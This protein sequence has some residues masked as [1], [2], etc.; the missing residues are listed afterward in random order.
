MISFSRLSVLALLIAPVLFVTA[1]ARQEGD[2]FTDKVRQAAEEAAYTGPAL[3]RVSDDD[4]NVYLFGTVHTMRPETKWQTEAVIAALEEADALY[5]EADVSSTQAQNDAAAVITEL[6]LLTNG[7]TLRDI[8]PEDAE[9]EVEEA[10]QLLGIPLQGLDN[11]Q[12]WYAS[13]ALT[14]IHLEKLGFDRSAGVEGVLGQRAARL[15]IPSRYLET[16]AEQLTIVASIPTSEQILM[17]QQTAEQIEDDPEFLDRMIAEWAEGDVEAL[18]D[19]ISSDDVFGSG[20]VY[21]LLLKKRNQNWTAQIEQLMAAEAGTFFIAVGAAHLAGQDSVQSM[22]RA[23]GL[24]VERE[25]P[26]PVED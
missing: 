25:N 11:L 5:L 14:D 19:M 8:L 2:S 7:D 3:W 15:A 6:G 16:G 9:T 17:L 23:E 24:A 20:A 22:L 10:A 4:T 18:A 13:F 21:D 1:C 12:P 26:R